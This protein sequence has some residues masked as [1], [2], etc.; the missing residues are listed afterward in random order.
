VPPLDPELITFFGQAWTLLASSQFRYWAGAAE[1]WGR[2]APE[3]L[4]NIAGSAGSEE[5]RATVVDAF[6]AGLGEL[7]DLQIAEARRLEAELAELARRV[8]PA[9][10]STAGEG[11]QRRWTVKE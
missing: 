5:K 11:Y 3:V 6:R 4:Q 2:I 10:E 9:R 8:W 7:A 1:V